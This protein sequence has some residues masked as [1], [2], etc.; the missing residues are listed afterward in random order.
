MSI[1]SIN[2]QTLKTWLENNTAILID[3]REI[4]ENKMARIKNS[5]LIPLAKVDLD[6]IPNL[7]NKKLVLHC[8][9]GKR[10]FAACEKLLSQDPDLEI[11]NLE[12]G[13]DSWIASNNAVETN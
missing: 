6:L 2:S 9:A 1:H 7:D 8:K 10:S 4:A 3:V 13:I 12:G 11:Y 5:T